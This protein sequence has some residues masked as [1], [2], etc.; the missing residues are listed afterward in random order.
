MPNV[1]SFFFSENVEGGMLQAVKI[2]A[3]KTLLLLLLSCFPFFFSFF[4]IILFQEK[5]SYFLTKDSIPFILILLSISKEFNK[6]T[7]LVYS[8]LSSSSVSWM[9][10]WISG[11]SCNSLR[12]IILINA[13]VW[14]VSSLN[15]FTK[16]RKRM[17]SVLYQK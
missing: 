17:R 2:A 9:N 6:C 15:C 10:S 14:L 11:T 16:G 5:L 8:I 1:G 12:G 13:N 4:F 3:I 7:T